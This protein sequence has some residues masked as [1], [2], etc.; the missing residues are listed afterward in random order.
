MDSNFLYA[1]D[2]N[3]RY[4]WSES[5]LHSTRLEESEEFLAAYPFLYIYID[6]SLKKRL[7]KEEDEGLL[8]LF[9]Y[10]NQFKRVYKNK[11]VE[12]WKIKRTEE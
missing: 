11:D 2:V 5:F 1:P 10:S 3:R 8:Y 9:R 7:W 6:D 4:N 12:I